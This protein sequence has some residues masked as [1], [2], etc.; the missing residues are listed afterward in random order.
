MRR[1]T[2]ILTVL[3]FIMMTA[4]SATCSFAVT[5]SDE[6]DPT[7]Y[8]YHR[9]GSGA[10]DGSSE[11]GDSQNSGGYDSTDPAEPDDQNSDSDDDTDSD[12]SDTASVPSAP[13]DTSWFDYKNPKKTYKIKNEAQLRGLASLVNEEQYAWKPNHTEDFSNTKFILV[14]DISLSGDWEP[15]G[16]GSSNSFKGTFDGE[17]HTIKGLNVKKGHDYSGLFGYLKGAVSNLNVEGSVNSLNSCTGAIAG[18]IDTE[19]SVTGCSTHVSVNGRDKTGGIVGESKGGTI[20]LCKS[21]G[22]VSGTY[23][24]GGIVGENFGG[25]VIQC[26]NSSEIKSTTRNI[27]IYGTG[28]VAGR[29]VSDGS[30]V[31]ECYNTGSITSA[32]EGTG[33]VVG[34]SNAKG[35]RIISSYNSGNIVIK[36]PS[37]GNKKSKSYAGGVVGIVCDNEVTVANCYNMG[38]CLG[39]DVSGGVAGFYTDNDSMSPEANITNNFYVSSEYKYGIGECLNAGGT[40]IENCTSGISLGA[41]KNA[42]GRLRNKFRN[43]SSGI[44]GNSGYPVLR[45]QD[46]LSEEDKEYLEGVSIDVQKRLDEYMAKHVDSIMIGEF[47]INIFNT[48]NLLQDYFD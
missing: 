42:S 4:M 21:H 37:H 32:T 29:S 11:Q 23:K 47:V 27:G 9:D 28:G 7:V 16:H 2:A 20:E 34:F 40:T 26:G 1:F 14:N 15:I 39:A 48:T 36:A 44:Y 10:P 41:L 13:V 24:I 35:A 6:T 8:T 22:D 3:V 45:W 17:G 43:D 33:G 38:T 18:R 5:Q 12:D 19:A 46:K 25:K 30:V 31:R